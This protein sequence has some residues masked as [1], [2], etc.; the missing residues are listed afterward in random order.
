MLGNRIDTGVRGADSC[1]KNTNET[2]MYIPL[3]PTLKNIFQNAAVRKLVTEE[4]PSQNQDFLRTY[5]DGTQ[6]KTHPFLTHYNHCI[7]LSLYCDE[8]EC[9]NAIGS[10]SSIHKISVFYFTM[11]NFL[12]F[13]TTV[14]KIFFC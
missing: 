12:L 5:M 4:K 3:I 8:I 7:R 11:Q 1:I 13:T 9:A 6:F 2:F 14:S 10:K